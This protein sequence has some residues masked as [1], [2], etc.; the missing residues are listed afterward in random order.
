MTMTSETMT[1]HITV[2][3]IA[4]Y[5][6]GLLPEQRESD[7]D[8]HLADC[9]ACTD[10]ARRWY[11]FSRIWNRWTAQAHGRAYRQARLREGP[12]PPA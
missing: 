3:E 10:Q 9:E 2:E 12:P 1:Q 8:M 11:A 4:D 7:L 5:F 6:E